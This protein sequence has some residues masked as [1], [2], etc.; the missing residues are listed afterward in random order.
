MSLKEVQEGGGQTGKGQREQEE[1][2]A[3]GEVDG[4]LRLGPE[5]AG[6]LDVGEDEVERHGGAE[7]GEGDDDLEEGLEPG[8]HREA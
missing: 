4:D 2:P 1:H 6:L 7:G 8:R 3:D 5:E